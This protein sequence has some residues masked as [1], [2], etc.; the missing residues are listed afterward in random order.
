MLGAQHRHA[1]TVSVLEG[2]WWG[3][4]GRPAARP[5]PEII[6]HQNKKKHTMEAYELVFQKGI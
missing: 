3:R 5:D 6:F 1:V 4:V 2:R